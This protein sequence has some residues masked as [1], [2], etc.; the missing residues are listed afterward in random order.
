M[1]A[2]LF[3]YKSDVTLI[4]NSGIQFLD[5]GLTPQWQDACAGRFVRQTANGPL[6][7]V[8]YDVIPGKFTL[9]GEKGSAPEVVKPESTLSLAHSLQIM[10]NVWLPLPFLRINASH[11]FTDGPDN[12][13]RI[14]ISSLA[15]PDS[16]GNTLRVTIAL[17]TRIP[18]IEQTDLSLAPDISDIRNGT[19]FALAWRDES[20]SHFLDNTWV[21]GWLREVFCHFYRDNAA[22][23]DNT[24]ARALKLF[25]YQG[26]Y[27]NILEMIGTQLAIPEVKI[28]TATLHDEAIPVDLVLDV[29]NTHTCGILIEDQGAE[30]DGL[31]QT[32][33]LQI[34]SLSEPHRINPPMFTSRLEF[35]EARFGK[36]HCSL[37][38][39]RHDA[40][41]WPSIVRVGDEAHRLACQR[42]GTE[43]ESGISSPR[44]YLWD[45]SPAHQNWRFSQI[46]VRTQR[47]PQ[48]TAFP[49]MSLMNDD[50]QPLYTLPIEERL[51]VFSA[52]YSR[53]SLM[54]L[55]LCELLAQALMQ[56]NSVGS[57]Q[58]MNHPAAP[59]HLRNLI[60][61]L[62]SAMPKPEREL[63]RLR[64]QEA[65]GLVW[66][67]LDWHPVDDDF[68][69][70]QAPLQS[71]R[72]IPQVQME[73]D[74]A[75]C[76]QLVWLYY[77]AI[78]NYAGQTERFFETLARAD[79]LSHDST[80][81][82]KTLRVA[83]VDIGGGT[84]DMAIVQY[85]L[86]EGRGRNVKITPRLLFREGFK[87]AGDDVL[88]DVIQHSVLPSLQ[89]AI[90]KA[91]VKDASGLMSSLF[92][93]A[94]R[95][96]TQA[97]LR[98][99]T[100]LQLFI[101][102]GHAIL[103]FWEKYGEETPDAILESTFGELLTQPLT[104]N[105]INYIQQAVQQAQGNNTTP[106][107]ILKVPLL[108]DIAQLNAALVGGKFSLT[109]PLQ[110]LCEVINL[111]CC[112]VLLITGRSGA[113]P[114]IQEQL[115][116]LQPVPV[117]RMVW[118]DNYQTQEGCPFTD[119]DARGNPKSTAAVG[120]MLYSLASDLRLPHF[121]F[122]AA[123][124]QAYS[125]IRYLG[126]LEESN[127]LRDENVWYRDID[128]DVPHG[129]LPG[130]LHFPLRGNVRLGFR[131]LD[132]ARWPA[133]SLYTLTINSPHLAKAVAGDNVL[134]V[135]LKQTA[136]AESFTLA[137]AWLSDGMPVPPEQL[138][139]KLNTLADGDNGATHYWIDNGSVYRK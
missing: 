76:G 56:I 2:P 137:K 95:Q 103:S 92:G 54:T 112:D 120:A 46:N 4:E 90:Q 104:E 48:A 44:R 37:E 130:E 18:T 75:T 31:R 53:S 79:R 66:K 106:F 19:R 121:N 45:T 43:G 115:R 135:A 24:L 82:G 114:G 84:T 25:E 72:P 67:A 100:T 20:L 11:I 34:R 17:D 107:D 123:D 55:M 50:G 83:S 87:V 109:A 74:E 134:N 139:F 133:T 59:R 80:E 96:E 113:L 89:N 94:I 91:G 86:D 36:Q 35:S 124:I 102:L 5:F 105:V 52:Q 63:F 33:E 32:S 101:P 68:N 111:Y 98:Q 125:T 131:Q 15:E 110:S 8:D 26:H 108:A 116:H 22:M 1:L 57:R 127:R 70:A 85:Q 97:I 136:D 138:S 126:V 38:S 6:L 93:E 7:R 69:S 42:L 41:V 10:N 77:E 39:G 88:L 9:P 65:V 13:A 61:T 16:A 117:N 12:W 14:Q 119:T 30:N 118:L 58:N 71:K 3:N 78:I 122:K 51:P 28:V 132:N 27:L 129:E 60:L 47:E 62:P 64:M 73:W 99:Q 23:D 128:L 40:F 29:G 21:D 49:L 81:A